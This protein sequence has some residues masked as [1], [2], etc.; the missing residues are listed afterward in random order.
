[1]EADYHWHRIPITK[2]VSKRYMIEDFNEAF[3]GAI[4]GKFLK[5]IF[6]F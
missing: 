3:T 2:I 4:S 1:M 5:I 6:K